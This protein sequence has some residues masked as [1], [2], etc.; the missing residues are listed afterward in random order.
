MLSIACPTPTRVHR[1]HNQVEEDRL[2]LIS[3]SSP[4][5]S[6]S[7]C[8]PVDC[9]T[10][11]SS[12][13]NG[14]LENDS[15]SPK[16]AVL[17]KLPATTSGIS[18]VRHENIYPDLFLHTKRQG[19]VPLVDGNY[20]T[21]VLHCC[22][23]WKERLSV[24]DNLILQVE[25]IKNKIYADAIKV[26]TNPDS[27]TTSGEEQSKTEHLPHV[28]NIQ[29]PSSMQDVNSRS[30]MGMGI[31]MTLPNVVG[32][33]QG[34]I[35]VEN[36]C[37]N[38]IANSHFFFQEQQRLMAAAAISSFPSYPVHSL[39]S[40]TTFPPANPLMLI[41]GCDPLFAASFA[42]TL[43]AAAANA[44]TGNNSYKASQS[45][46][47]SSVTA[48]TVNADFPL[49]LSR[50]KAP[51]SSNI[52]IKRNGSLLKN[53]S[54]DIMNQNAI[55]TCAN[56][57]RHCDN[58]LSESPKEHLL[59]VTCNENQHNNAHK[60]TGTSFGQRIGS[61]TPPIRQGLVSRSPDHIKRP[62][63]AFMVWARDERRKML[64]SCPDMHNSNISKILGERWKSMSSDEKQPYYEE[65]S[66]LSKLHMQQHPNYRYN[67]I[68]CLSSVTS[69]QS[70]FLRP[71]P[72]R[73][74]IVDGKR[75]R[76]SE[77][78]QLLRTKQASWSAMNAGMTVL[79]ATSNLD[80][81]ASDISDT[82]EHANI[83]QIVM[84]LR[85]T[86]TILFDGYLGKKANA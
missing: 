65:Q 56:A 64:K 6:T 79:S 17:R 34:Q 7:S 61:K 57:K 22:S 9:S 86:L 68:F 83:Y 31:N 76:L 46:S 40:L 15:C 29:S 78:K 73:T 49:N 72:K 84:K 30:P 37:S 20:L 69:L 36:D 14:V 77:Y 33:I 3:G 59:L 11:S 50:P 43:A 18:D 53:R 8:S 28:R 81:S 62:M 1:T 66:R 71:R 4:S 41:G 16:A 60:V 27:E 32:S 38:A 75:V 39:T 12:T 24:L 52:E 42:S 82:S 51:A 2:H 23:D 55:P 21:E 67:N 80:V 44:T 47:A 74:C 25:D 48:P 26:D 70:V 54:S 10:A 63:N 58:G 45:S 5:L 85:F 13:S 19:L 35:T